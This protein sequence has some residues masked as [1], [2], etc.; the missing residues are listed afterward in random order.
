ML[1]FYLLACSTTS[2][3]AVL[4]DGVWALTGL[5]AAGQLQIDA[6]QC[7]VSIWGNGYTTGQHAVACELVANEEEIFVRFPIEFG[8]G[9]ATV[10]ASMSAEL[11]RFSLPLGSRLGE[12][13][14][15]FSVQSG[16]LD[17]SKAALAVETA[18]RGLDFSRA[19]WEQSVFRLEK[20]GVLHG[21]VFL[22]ADRAAELQLYS[23]V[24][25]TRGRV[26]AVLL[27]QG[28]DLW[29]KFEIMPSLDGEEG[30][31]VLSRALNRAVLPLSQTPSAIEHTFA[32]QPGNVSDDERAR[33]VSA[34]LAI[35]LERERTV[36]RHLT[37]SLHEQAMMSQCIGFSELS[38][39]EPGLAVLWK[40]YDVSVA[41]QDENCVVKVEPNVVQYGRRIAHRYGGNGRF[42]EAVR[43]LDVQ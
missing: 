7:S 18:E 37:I 14:I 40:G 39:A 20:E 21:E 24:G 32:L 16:P 1:F 11:E 13:E 6:G 35:G 30:V 5:D 23:D 8:V 22:P 38:A 27:E 3:K 17:V 36:L 19:L 41:V 9:K 25:V 34:I 29:L 43:K 33:R 26:V 2:P 12:N 10:A 28:A 31:L 42:V 4:E 15:Q